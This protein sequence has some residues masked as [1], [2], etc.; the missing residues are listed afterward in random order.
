MDRVA[1][2]NL[3]TVKRYS[4]LLKRN[5]VSIIFPTVTIWAIYADWSR[6]QRFKLQTAAI[7]QANI[8]PELLKD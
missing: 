4:R 2:S 6:T 8:N 5:F 7:R 3:S 1:V